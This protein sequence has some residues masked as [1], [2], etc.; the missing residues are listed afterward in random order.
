MD[1]QKVNEAKLQAYGLRTQFFP[2]R[3]YSLPELDAEVALMNE[4]RT[5][6]DVF[7]PVSTA[8]SAED[9]T[10]RKQKPRMQGEK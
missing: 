10:P 2:G 5:Y 4:K 1:E 6:L 7:G 8:K 3:T 9:I